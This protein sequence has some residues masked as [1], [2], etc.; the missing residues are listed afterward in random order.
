[1]VTVYEIIHEYAKTNFPND[2]ILHDLIAIDY[3]LHP[4]IKPKT[5]FIEELERAERTSIIERLRLNHHKFR[6]IIIP[7]NFDF[8][9]WQQSEK[10]VAGKHHLIFQY[11]GT[12]K[13]DVIFEHS[14][15]VRI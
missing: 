8:E 9:T 14:E 3:Y 12:T 5:L 7:I 6:F 4:N 2:I 11:N 10:I 1:L 13:P 15:V